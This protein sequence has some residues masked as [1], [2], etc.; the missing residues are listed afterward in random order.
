MIQN[1]DTG[2]MQRLYDVD[3][4][5]HAPDGASDGAYDLIFEAASAEEISQALLGVLQ[6]GFGLADGD[7]IVPGCELRLT[8]REVTR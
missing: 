5:C 6:G 1:P 4:S 2:E 7:G 8:I 3:A